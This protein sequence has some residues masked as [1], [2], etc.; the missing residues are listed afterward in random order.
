MSLDYAKTSQKRFEVPN[1]R[2]LIKVLGG[3]G[4][5]GGTAETRTGE[6]LY[7]TQSQ[8]MPFL[9]MGGVGGTLPNP[10]KII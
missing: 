9:S 4:G 6:K 8:P 10:L 3:M 2:I 5:M 7:I 1:T